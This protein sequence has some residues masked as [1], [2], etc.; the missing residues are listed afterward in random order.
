M[1]RR[2]AVTGLGIVSCLGNDLDTVEAA[3][4][5]S[6]S[7]LSHVPDY[8]ERGLRSHVAGIPD[9]S[10]LPAVN[11]KIG[12]FMGDAALYAYHAACDALKDAAMSGEQVGSVR[13]GLIVGSGVGSP[14][15]HI[16]AID[17]LNERGLEKVLPYAV[18]RV[19]G[20]TT[21][22]CLSTAFGIKG[23]SYSITS[24]CATA[25]HCIGH[26]TEL[27]QL[28]K[29]DTVI[30]GGS[31][32]VRWTSTAL[33]DA[34]GA[35]STGY[36]DT[37]ASRPFD[38][39]R[40][41][42]VIAGGA[43]ILVLEEME[44]AIRRGAHI[45][46]EVVGYG[47]CSDG[48]DMVNPS[49]D[50]AARAMRLALTE[51]DES[52]DY[53]NAHATSTVVG[54]ICELKAIREVF[55]DTVPLISSTKGLTG[56]P[57][58]ASAAHEAIYSILMLERG[59]VAGCANLRDPDPATTGL[60]ILSRNIERQVDTIMSNSFGFGGTNASLVFRKFLI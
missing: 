28:G 26:G 52:V 38:K 25:A 36:N 7:G 54:D 48:S 27:I 56:H 40:D 53:I 24:A 58:A 29:M 14:F 5:E 34:M 42:F 21:S 20:S 16:H 1:K 35:L 23:A 43:G 19:M 32:E 3:L 17:T 10:R 57:I 41:G 9:I 22:A 13:T 12:R 2:V 4:R 60:P 39:G 55:G 59:F 50:G 8:V 45:Y 30:V 18:P 49:P 11:R 37:S 33:F 46:A 15:E 6:R 31:E 44:Q 47:A 51:V